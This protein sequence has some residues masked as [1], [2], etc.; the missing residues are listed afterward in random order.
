M[1]KLLFQSLFLSTVDRSRTIAGRCRGERARNSRRPR[2]AAAARPQFVD[3]RGRCR[4]L[5]WVRTRNPRAQQCLLRRRAFWTSLRRLAASRRCVDGDR[6][7]DQKHARSAGAH[8]SCDPQSQMGDRDRRLR[9]GW[10]LFRRQLRGRW[11]CLRSHPGR[12]PHPRLSAYSNWRC[13]R[14]LLALLEQT[15]TAAVTP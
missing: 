12:P 14:A 6:S 15:D 13:C 1:R 8:L 3:P 10:R 11:R 2:G 7:G 9:A 5:Q 4:I